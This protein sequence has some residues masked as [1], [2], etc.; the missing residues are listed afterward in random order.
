MERTLEADEVGGIW[1]KPTINNFT[2]YGLGIE[3]NHVCCQSWQPYG[4]TSI[5]IHGIDSY[6]VFPIYSLWKA[7]YLNMM[8]ITALA[9]SFV[10]LVELN[11]KKKMHIIKVKC[12]NARCPLYSEDRLK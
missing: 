5:S 12:L 9:P 2:D 1:A 7:I 4:G 10:G 6:L 3:T 8:A 11:N